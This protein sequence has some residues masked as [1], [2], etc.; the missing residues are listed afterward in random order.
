M[1]PPREQGVESVPPALP[2]NAM[3]SKKKIGVLLPTEG[4]L[5]VARVGVNFPLEGPK[6]ERK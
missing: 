3:V 1:S 5:D 6:D 4:E 2:E